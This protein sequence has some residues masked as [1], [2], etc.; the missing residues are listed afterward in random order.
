MEHE[1]II[2][3]LPEF[4]DG[5]LSETEMASIEKHLAGCEGCCRALAGWRMAVKAF[6]ATP[7][8][9]SRESTEA[10]VREVMVRLP[11]AP[12]ARSWFEIPDLRWL[13]PVVGFSVAVFLL[14]FLPYVRGQAGAADPVLADPNARVLSVWLHRAEAGGR[15]ALFELLQEGI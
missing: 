10:L 11:A 3:K 7:R 15:N 9:T 13:V 5:E 6:F 12:S 4:I 2:Q 14:S 8:H 1:E